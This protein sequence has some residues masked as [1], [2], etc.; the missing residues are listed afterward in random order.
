[1]FDTI[2]H[3]FLISQMLVVGSTYWN[4]GIGRDKGEVEG[5]EEGTRTMVRLGENMAWLLHKLAD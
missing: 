4:V 3:F 2:N 5:D 1:V